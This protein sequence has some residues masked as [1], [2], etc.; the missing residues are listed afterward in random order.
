MQPRFF[1]MEV[2]GIDISSA[3]ESANMVSF[4]SIPYV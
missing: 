1:K 4:N 3:H 2:A